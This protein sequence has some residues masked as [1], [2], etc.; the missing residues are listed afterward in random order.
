MGHSLLHSLDQSLATSQVTKD[1]NSGTSDTERPR[2]RELD[3]PTV[4]HQGNPLRP[5]SN[6][7]SNAEPLPVAPAEIRKTTIQQVGST[8]AETDRLSADQAL[9]QVGLQ[10]PDEVGTMAGLV[11]QPVTFAPSF[12]DPTS[13][14]LGAATTIASNL[15]ADQLR[16]WG[17][18]LA[19][20]PT[21]SDQTIEIAGRYFTKSLFQHHRNRLPLAISLELNDR[22]LENNHPDL[23]AGMSNQIPAR[24][25]VTALPPTD[26]GSDVIVAEPIK[27]AKQPL[28]TLDPLSKTQESVFKQANEEL[29]E[30][31]LTR[32]ADVQREQAVLRQVGLSD[33]IDQAIAQS[34]KIRMLQRRPALAE[35]ETERERSIF[36]PVMRLDTK[37]RDDA[38]P[39]ANQ[40]QT[41]GPPILKDNTWSA[42]AGVQRRFA[43]GTTADLS[44]RLG[45]KN[46]NSTF[47]SPQD[48]GTAT[49]GLDVTHPLLRNSG[50]E[51]NRSLIVLAELQGQVS[52]FEYQAD[53]Q[54]EMVEIGT[55]YWQLLHAR[56]V[57]L[58][59]ERS[60]DR[61]KQVLDILTARA[62]YDASANQVAAAKSDVSQRE[63]ELLDAQRSLREIEVLLRDK[64][65]DADFASDQDVELIP[66]EFFDEVFPQEY[67]ALHDAI[68]R[69]LVNRWELQREDTRTQ[70]ADRQLF[71][72]RCGLAP[73]LDLVLGVY[74]SG[75]AGDT[76]IERAWANQFGASTPGYYG[77]LEYEI[78]YGRRQ[79][80]AAVQRDELQKQQAMDAYQVARNEVITQVKTAHIRV[81][82]AIQSRAAAAQSVLD[83]RAAL[84]HM[85]Q[86]WEA[87]ALVEGNATQGTSP[88]IALE[89][90]LTGQRRLQ[91]AEIRLAS[92]DLQLALTRQSLLL[93]MGEVMQTQVASVAEPG[94]SI[95]PTPTERIPN[96]SSSDES[97][98]HELAPNEP[99][100][101]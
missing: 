62:N 85:Q 44:Q 41:G 3:K 22:A 70:A 52:F 37:Y 79:A 5:R 92:A 101:R 57:L 11:R 49:L 15:E 55:L 31:W 77:G 40:L 48:Q 32:V 63:T 46:S 24:P 93:A 84:A 33:L 60:R 36:D 54:R 8:S 42:T 16:L 2:L 80:K 43:S 75:L 13:I 98:P 97:A 19:T 59:T 64:I 23:R 99:T 38:D 45:F 89:Q 73:K 56:Q 90:L 74:A 67:V 66:V 35:T 81:E 95:A 39:V 4:L 72:S 61:A 20:A 68:D 26:L 34:P 83:M 9:W 28:T 47:F 65:N 6:M 94:Q 7:E 14:G 51:F 96:A 10:P 87:A 91:D 88:S 1:E 58:Q 78:P 53:L 21:E 86:R 76:G 17:D 27:L 29:P 50:R 30:W 12:L 18:P 25:V 69:A 71:M 82:T 100:P